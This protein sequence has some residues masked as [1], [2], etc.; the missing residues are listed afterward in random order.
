MKTVLFAWELG[1][2]LGHVGG[3]R[4]VARE[5]AAHGHQA[6][7]AVRDVGSRALVKDDG[8]PVLQAPVWL[9]PVPRGYL[10]TGSY[11]DILAIHGFADADDLSMMV[12]AWQ[13]LFDVVKPD[14]IVVDHSPTACLAAYGAV[15]VALIGN[16]FTV[17]PMEFPS[18]P[19]IRPEVP[20]TVPEQRLIEV[21]HAVQRRRKRSAPETLPGLLASPVRSVCT[22]PELDPYHGVRSEP[23]VGAIGA[24][25]AR[26]P[27][28]AEPALFA[29][30]AAD[31][32]AI[33]D[34]VL[35][36]AEVDVP[37]SVYFRGNAGSL[38]RFLK[39]QGIHVYDN[40]PPLTE[41][42]PKVS[43]ILHHGGNHTAHA[44]LASGRPQVVLPQHLEAELTAGAIEAMGVGIRL[45]NNVTKENLQDALRQV[46]HEP[47]IPDCAFRL[48]RAIEERET[49]DALSRTVAGCLELLSQ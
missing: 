8:Y 25:P 35:C 32:G 44:G 5:L 38:P 23:V 27:P 4:S 42:L 41:V 26:T 19:P 49:V 9:Q 2:G 39:G 6:V 31:F 7:F 34:L 46:L 37:V 20:P 24:L 21:V 18:F 33:E 17:P 11:A 28:P 22:L 15:P 30:C 14:L 36:L 10:G 13:D 1:E 29:Y 16:G 47:D 12:A 40:P 45:A 3:L 48:A 43:A